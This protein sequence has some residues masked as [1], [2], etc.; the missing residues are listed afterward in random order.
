[1]VHLILLVN[2]VLWLIRHIGLRALR[3]SDRHV[4]NVDKVTKPVLGQANLQQ[5]SL[6]FTRLPAEIRSMIYCLAFPK[7]TIHVRDG[8]GGLAGMAYKEGSE[9]SCLDCLLG[10][11][12]HEGFGRLNL[13]SLP[14]S[15]RM[16]YAETIPVVYQQNRLLFT[17]VKDWQKFF[18]SMIKHQQFT[19][20]ALQ[21]LRSVQL[22]Y[23]VSGRQTFNSY[24]EAVLIASLKVLAEQAHSLENLHIHI[25]GYRIKYRSDLQPLSLKTFEALGQLRGLSA[26]EFGSQHPLRA[27]TRISLHGTQIRANYEDK[28]AA[29]ENVLGDFV[30]LPRGT[31]L[32]SYQANKALAMAYQQI[33]HQKESAA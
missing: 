16:A 15:C 21:S 5:S 6:F 33:M 29:L 3:R 2:T 17:L 32:P 14:L 28:T 8:E 31:Q 9:E 12:C 11:E 30:Y 4:L 22:D 24:D 1:M 7:H 19:H 20:G 25:P 27:F 13:L 23:R 26:F 10:P 18:D